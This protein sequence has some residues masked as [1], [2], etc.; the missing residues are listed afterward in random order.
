MYKQINAS[1]GQFSMNTL[2]A[3]TGALASN[4]AGDTTYANT[5]TALQSLGSQRDAL[6]NEIR[7]ALWNAEFN[8]QKIDEQQAKDWIEQGRGLPRPGRRALRR[9]SRR[10]RTRRSSRRSTTSW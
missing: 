5:E 10:H 9:S 4:T 6:A 3:S 8:G 1:F 2:C 7:A